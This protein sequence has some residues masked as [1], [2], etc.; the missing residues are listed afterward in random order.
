[1][2]YD[3][4]ADKILFVSLL[5][6]IC[7][8]EMMCVSFTLRY[9]NRRA[10][11]SISSVPAITICDTFTWGNTVTSVSPDPCY[12]SSWQTIQ[13]P[14]NN[15]WAVNISDTELQFLWSW[16]WKGKATHYPGL[17]SSA[18]YLRLF[19]VV[20]VLVCSFSNCRVFPCVT[21]VKPLLT[22]PDILPMDMQCQ[23]FP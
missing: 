17:C 8:T 3:R 9:H 22:S 15:S 18:V 6:S 12:P 11:Q 4:T 20:L 23:T 21:C 19:K 2:L 14:I 5:C 13:L 16:L 7:A 1:M 10:A